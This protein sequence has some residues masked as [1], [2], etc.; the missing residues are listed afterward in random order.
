MAVI[1]WYPATFNWPLSN[2]II[3]EM[4]VNDKPG[5]CPSCPRLEGHE[6]CQKQAGGILQQYAIKPPR[7]CERSSV[8]RQG[9]SEVGLG[10]PRRFGKNVT[11]NS[12]SYPPANCR[13]PEIAYTRGEE[14]KVEDTGNNPDRLVYKWSSAWSMEQMGRTDKGDFANWG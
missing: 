5:N 10:L 1:A 9:L 7:N 3:I 11:A 6:D 14:A 12:A 13:R 2:A 8:H 4:M